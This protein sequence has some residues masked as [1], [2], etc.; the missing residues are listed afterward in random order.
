[1][2]DN[3][4]GSCTSCLQPQDS[5]LHNALRPLNSLST[6]CIASS[7]K[8]SS[9]NL[10]WSW[11]QA[12]WVTARVYDVA[13]LC[14]DCSLALNGLF[15]V[16]V[17]RRLFHCALGR[18]APRP[19]HV[20]QGY[21]LSQACTHVS[22]RPRHRSIHQGSCVVACS[23]ARVHRVPANQK[24]YEDKMSHIPPPLPP[25]THLRCIDV[26]S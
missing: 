4:G 21:V 24:R 22:V 1:M 15:Q 5:H 26:W 3:T 16:Y 23:S 2:A 25:R 19:A 11:T 12:A 6:R 8:M 13:Y 10:P 20:H 17:L 14:F 18:C 7:V 9:Q